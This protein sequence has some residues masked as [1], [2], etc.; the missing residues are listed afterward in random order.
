[1]WVI[2]AADGGV[3]AVEPVMLGVA[4]LVLGAIAGAVLVGMGVLASRATTS[5]RLATSRRCG[6]W[7]V[8]SLSMPAQCETATF[9]LTRQILR[10]AER[11]KKWM[12]P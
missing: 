10:S 4:G 3:L 5:A 6:R 1:M 11:D 2:V 9:W 7:L 12:F 8:P